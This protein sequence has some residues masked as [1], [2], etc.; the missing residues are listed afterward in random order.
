MNLKND[1]SLQE[2]T[3]YVKENIDKKDYNSLVKKAKKNE[4]IVSKFNSKE[5]FFYNIKD[6]D[7]KAIKHYHFTYLAND[8]VSIEKGLDSTGNVISQKIY[9]QYDRNSQLSWSASGEVIKF[10]INE[11][12]VKLDS[13]VK[14]FIKEKNAEKED[15]KRFTTDMLQYIQIEFLNK[16]GVWAITYQVPSQKTYKNFREETSIMIIDA[17]TGAVIENL[18]SLNKDCI[19]GTP[20]NYEK[21]RDGYFRPTEK[22]H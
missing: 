6:N 19:L 9:P 16:S 2:Y 11:F 15:L 10:G 21:Y 7:N 4:K 1:N 14:I 17:K 22:A 12:P 13:I 8:L 20:I 5:C 3:N 18:K